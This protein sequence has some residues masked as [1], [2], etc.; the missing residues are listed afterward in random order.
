MNLKKTKHKHNQI[1]VLI[2]LYFSKFA[3]SK[4]VFKT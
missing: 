2:K 1:V 4:I 3:L